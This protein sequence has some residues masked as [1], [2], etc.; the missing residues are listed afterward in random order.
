MEKFAP[1]PMPERSV[2]VL[3]G[4]G[5]YI[6]RIC[7]LLNAEKSVL[8]QSDHVLLSSIDERLAPNSVWREK[9]TQW[10]YDVADH[11]CE[12]RSIVYV[13]V[14]ILDRY[15]VAT[16]SSQ[17]CTM[18]KESYE[19]ASLSAIFLAMR[20]AGSVEVRLD[21]MIRMSRRALTTQQLVQ[22]GMDM[23]KELT[24]EHRIIVPQEFVSALA[25]YLPP[26]E[27]AESVVD[28]AYYLSELSVCDSSLARHKAS[29][30]ALAAIL[31]TLAAD[32][33]ADLTI[34]AIRKSTPMDPD[35]ETVADLRIRLH[36]LYGLSYERIN[37]SL[38][39]IVSND[40]NNDCQP[41]FLSSCATRI[42]SDENLVAFDDVDMISTIK[43]KSDAEVE[44]FADT[45]RKRSKTWPI[46]TANFK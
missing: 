39:H 13:A 10:M 16:Q 29:D 33:T 11:F 30:I 44:S 43:R 34:K 37:E 46:S 4:S 24:W 18:S 28:A 42:I 2:D 45:K 21:D 20:I 27:R 17:R 40:E 25:A 32:E 5:E 1:R 3:G 31:N 23:I 19:N 12:K 6:Q 15:C 35:C 41:D 36:R 14:N 22:S 9:V 7:S 8:A 26:S 38:P